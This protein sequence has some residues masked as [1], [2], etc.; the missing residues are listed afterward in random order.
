MVSYWCPLSQRRA[1]VPSAVGG[2]ASSDCKVGDEAGVH[3][4]ASERTRVD[5][6]EGGSGEDG[7]EELHVAVDVACL[8]VLR[9]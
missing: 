7:G 9:I 6:D 2:N 4:A 3:V 1:S 8:V 5:V